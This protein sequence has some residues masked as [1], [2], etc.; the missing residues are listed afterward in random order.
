MDIFTFYVGQGDLTVVRHDGEA[1]V[2]DS[3]LPSSPDELRAGI[4]R[5]LDLLLRDQVVS[6]L[7][8]TGF[9]ADHACPDGVDFILSTYKPRWIMYPKYY[10]DSDNAAAVFDIITSEERKRPLQRVSVRLDQLASQSRTLQGLLTHFSCELFS[11][12]T[13]DMDCSNN[14]SIVLKLSGIGDSGFSYLITGDTENSRWE[15]I[16]EFFGTALRASV[17]SAAHHGSKHGTDAEMILLVEPN[18]VLISAGVDNQY[19]HPDPQAVSAYNRVA[20]HVFATNVE[21]GVSL[22]TKKNGA[23]FETQLVR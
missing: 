21:G 3:Y 10:K 14:C 22:F 13:E 15:R 16:T 8:L 20:A 2:V 5:K 19:G 17:L 23:D 7:I 1:V 9:D 18:T 4:Q 11:P 12:H 6:G